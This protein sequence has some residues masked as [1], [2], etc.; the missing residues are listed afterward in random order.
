MPSTTQQRVF[1]AGADGFLG[2]VFT[3]RLAALRGYCVTHGTR[4]RF[5]LTRLADCRRAVRGMG[6]V[7][8]AAGLVT[9]RRDQE[10]RPA[11]ILYVNTLI[12]MQLLE[13]CRREG[14]KR[15]VGV[16]SIT[17]YPAS[18][19]SPL[20]TDMLLR[21]APG[22][23]G[24]AGFYGVSKWLAPVTASAYAS[25]YGIRTRIAVFPNLYGPAD[26]FDGSPPPLVPNFVA[27]LVAASRA[28]APIFDAGLNPLTGVDLLYVDD[29]S[30]FLV[31]LIRRFGDEDFLLVNAGSG[32][33][34][35][36]KTVCATVARQTGFQGTITWRNRGGVGRRFLSNGLAARRYGWRPKVALENGIRRTVQWFLHQRH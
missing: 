19:T 17:A 20:S 5:D 21:R 12:Q 13:A 11:D 35:S 31:R 1:I 32:R 6:L 25:Q 14:V 8:N 24:R 28:H 16:G 7:V 2:R 36:V 26:K 27:G 9:S 3:R 33:S 23:D 29:A 4:R 18:A 30:D 34:V 22:I 10:R 15:F